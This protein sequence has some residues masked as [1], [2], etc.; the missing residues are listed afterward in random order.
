MRVHDR[1]APFL[2][3]NRTFDAPRERVFRAWTEPE[4]IKQWF[5]PGKYQTPIVE[6]DLRPGG[7]YRFGLQLPG[8]NA[9][10]LSG[11]FREVHPPERL[12]YTWQWAEPTDFPGESLV[13]VQFLDRGGRT[14]V[15]ILHEQF[16][17]TTERDRH[18]EGW[19]GSLDKLEKRL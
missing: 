17:H 2:Q 16:S 14:E 1:E 15:V 10:F 6:V 11:T 7:H 8:G 13:T 3:L 12:V 19:N 18:I 9:F 5:G 4:E